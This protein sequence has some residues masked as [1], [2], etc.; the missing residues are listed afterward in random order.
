M[1]EK[2]SGLANIVEG[3]ANTVLIKTGVSVSSQFLCFIKDFHG[4]YVLS[5]LLRKRFV[6]LIFY[7]TI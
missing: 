1:E 7:V 5:A 6:K 3:T 2:I 4:K